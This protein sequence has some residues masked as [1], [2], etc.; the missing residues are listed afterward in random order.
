VFNGIG[1]KGTVEQARNAPIDRYV[2]V[3]GN[4][5]SHL[6]ENY[7]IFQDKTGEI[8]VEIENQV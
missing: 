1:I 6:R 5:I 4:I 7:Y 3:T 8:R 2:I